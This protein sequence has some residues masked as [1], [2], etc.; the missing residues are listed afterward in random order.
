MKILLVHPET[1]EA[2]FEE[3]KDLDDAYN[4]FG[5]GH[6]EIIEAPSGSMF[7]KHYAT[8]EILQVEIVTKAST[9]EIVVRNSR[10]KFMVCYKNDDGKYQIRRTSFFRIE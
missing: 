9:G 10:G 6:A 4:K 5:S 2:F 3:V 1:N 7:F 8:D